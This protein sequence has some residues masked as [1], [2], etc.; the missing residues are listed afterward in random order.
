MPIRRLRSARVCCVLR[1]VGSAAYARLV[2]GMGGRVGWGSA[3]VLSAVVYA[4]GCIC[5]WL[6]LCLGLPPLYFP[7]GCHACFDCARLEHSPISRVG[8][9]LLLADLALLARLAWCS[10][11]LRFLSSTLALWSLAAW[12][13]FKK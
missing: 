12:L 7:N 4:L 13:W 10:L 9:G 11:V 6:N 3:R 1:W 5:F 8:R 2:V